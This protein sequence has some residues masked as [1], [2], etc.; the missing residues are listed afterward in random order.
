MMD[1][2][3]QQQKQ[4]AMAVLAYLEKTNWTTKAA[5][6]FRKELHV[7]FGDLSSTMDNGAESSYN[8]VLQKKETT[9]KIAVESDS[10]SQQLTT[11]PL[12]QGTRAAFP[13]RRYCSLSAP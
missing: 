5:K 11:P 12:I 7:N 9:T 6:A 2:Q 10:R 13:V 1:E 8:L 4:M 3:Q